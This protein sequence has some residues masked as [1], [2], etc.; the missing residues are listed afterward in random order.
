V[1]IVFLTVGDPQRMTGGYLY[2]HEVFRRLQAGGDSVEQVVLSGASIEEQLAGQVQVPEQLPAADVLLVDALARVVCAPH[3]ARL[4]AATP[5]VAMVHELPGAAGSPDPREAGWITPLL[6]ADRLISVSRDGAEQLRAAGVPAERIGIASGGR[7]RYAALRPRR[8]AQARVVLCVAQWIRRKGIIELIR[9]W[10]QARPAGWQLV[11][12]G[13]TGAAADYRSEVLTAIGD[14]ATIRVLG[15]AADSVLASWY[16]RA[17]AFALLTQF[18]GY[19]L[20]LAEALDAG[21]PVIA[22]AV[23]PV[24]ALVGD[25]GLLVD[26]HDPAV[27]AD[28]LRRL[29][30]DSR[31]RRQLTAAARRRAQQLPDWQDTTRRLRAIC[32]AAM[33]DHQR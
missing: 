17:Q 30:N 12:A 2:H 14:D 4:Q 11:F 8:R 28:A 19:G 1:R 25:A 29:C 20:V 18:E 33:R 10:Q 27:A 9:A 26:P 22:G 6:G 31:L 24:P 3:L 15:A 16:A 13:E 32:A 21:L 5:L 7:D 23:G